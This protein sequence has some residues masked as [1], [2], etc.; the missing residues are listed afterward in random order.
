MGSPEPSS[1]AGEPGVQPCTLQTCL[2][3]DR[4]DTGVY[5]IGEHCVLHSRIF[6]D[7]GLVW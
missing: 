4:A 1:A 5:S 7:V 6:E 3:L 2:D